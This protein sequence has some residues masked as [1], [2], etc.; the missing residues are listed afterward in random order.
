[1]YHQIEYTIYQRY[2]Q[3]IPKKK[4]NSKLQHHLHYSTL[5]DI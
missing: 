2:Q 5:I 4:L 1:M 3:T